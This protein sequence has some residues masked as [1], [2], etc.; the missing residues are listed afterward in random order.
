MF[1]FVIFALLFRN[2][3]PQIKD[4]ELNSKTRLDVEYKGCQS[5]D[6]STQSLPLSGTPNA[7]QHRIPVRVRDLSLG[8]NV[9]LQGH[10]L[11]LFP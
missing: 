5:H 6:Q 8:V 1:S 7:Q 10:I 2:A 3:F 9:R 4:E 11:Y